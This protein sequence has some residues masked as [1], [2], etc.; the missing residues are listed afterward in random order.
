[1]IIFEDYVLTNINLN[2]MAYYIRLKDGKEYDVWKHKKTPV[3][4]YIIK[5]GEEIKLDKDVAKAYLL[6]VRV[7]ERDGI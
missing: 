2:T 5:E 7:Y 1:M 6:E 3:Y 4:Y